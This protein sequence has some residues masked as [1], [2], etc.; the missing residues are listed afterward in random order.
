M[1]MILVSVLVSIFCLT[2]AATLKW[3]A[4]NYPMTKSDQREIEKDE[5][6]RSSQYIRDV[7][8]I[9]SLKN[10]KF[11]KGLRHQKK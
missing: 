5:Y 9:K 2:V 4:T 3:L 1:N 10:S 7:S 11:N 8:D 6:L